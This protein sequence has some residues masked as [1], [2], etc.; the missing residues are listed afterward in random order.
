MRPGKSHETEGSHTCRLSHRGCTASRFGQDSAQLSPS[1]ARREPHKMWPKM[2]YDMKGLVNNN[3][4]NIEPI[5]ATEELASLVKQG[6]ASLFQPG[7]GPPPRFGNFPKLGKGGIFF[8]NYKFYMTCFGLIKL[9][10]SNFWMLVTL[11]MLYT[12][13]IW[14][15]Y[16][17]LQIWN[18]YKNPL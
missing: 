1:R 2:K 14:N 5:H 7:G 13:Q 10:S 4:Y 17:L 6:C 12:S 11:L 18:C 16:K 9:E 3:P 8:E 15:C